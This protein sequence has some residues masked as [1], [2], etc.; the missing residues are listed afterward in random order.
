VTRTRYV[1]RWG[2]YQGGCDSPGSSVLDGA[3]EDTVSVLSFLIGVLGASWLSLLLSVVFA[4][5]ALGIALAT[6]DVLKSLSETILDGHD[7]CRGLIE[8]VVDL[9]LDLRV[10]LVVILLELDLGDSLLDLSDEISESLFSGLA[11]ILSVD[12][13][14]LLGNLF[15]LIFLD[16]DFLLLDGGLPRLL[17]TSHLV[18]LGGHLVQLFVEDLDD[19]FLVMLVDEVKESG[20]HLVRDLIR[21]LFDGVINSLC[22]QCVLEL[23]D[24]GLAS[25]KCLNF[26]GVLL[27]DFLPIL[28]LLG[29]IDGVEGNAKVAEETVGSDHL[30]LLGIGSSGSILLSNRILLLEFCDHVSELALDPLVLLQSAAESSSLRLELSEVARELLVGRRSRDLVIVVS[31]TLGGLWCFLLSGLGHGVRKYLN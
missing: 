12:L 18:D 7:L 24:D 11:L 23:V 29:L 13:L 2:S 20:Y 31:S 6:L 15:L 3:G 10:G 1:Q 8:E 25:E 5:S 21:E 30:L 17:F 16:C 27:W 22:L 26:F 19:L 14:W 28:V 9:R 4:L